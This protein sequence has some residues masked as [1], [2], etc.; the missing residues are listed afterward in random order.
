MLDRARFL[1]V[2]ATLALPFLVACGG[3][4][5]PSADMGSAP[6]DGPE[7]PEVDLG[8]GEEPDVCEQEGL[9]RAAFRAGAGTVFGEVAGDF[10]VRT[11][12][13][14]WQLSESF[15]GCESYVFITYIP[16]LRQSPIGP[17][18]GDEMWDT[19][20]DDLF[21]IGPRNVR[22]FFS[23]FEASEV[24]RRERME[25]MRDNVAE[26]L[27]VFVDDE[28]DRAF[29]RERFH[30]VTDR[31]TEIEGSVGAMV[32]SYFA[33]LGTEE[34]LTDLGDRGVVQAPL[35]FAFGIDREQRFD[36]G[37]SLSPVVGATLEMGM[38]AYFG[39][40]YNAK[41]ELAERLAAEEATTTV[42]PLLEDTV[43]DRVFV[44]AV[45]LPD[46]ATMAAFDTLEVE[47][48]VE[49]TA[50]S[51]FECSEWDRIARVEV[52]L[53]AECAERR[54][55]VRWIT[56]YWR[57]GR[58]HWSIDATPMLGLLLEGGERTFRIEMGPSWERA[59]PRRA[60]IALRLG[61]RD[62]E[63]KPVATVPAFGGGRFDETYNDREP[64]AFT[65][66]ADAGRVELVVILS[67]HGDDD[68]SRCAEWCDH[69][70]EFAVNDAPLD[71]IAHG[72]EVGTTAGC[73]LRADEGIPPGQWG[74]WAPERA[75]WCPGLPVD[76][77]RIDITDRVTLGQENTLTYAGGVGPSSTPGG[78]NISLSSYLVYYR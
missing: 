46:A 26:G 27:E 71:R 74:N 44:E 2:P 47:V 51:P 52:C 6:D 4:T 20:P 7:I 66:P 43:T 77:I 15:S 58:R 21:R 72:G 75:F 19:Y 22:Y 57:R 54:E 36:A 48:E 73:A 18:Q 37:G 69:R 1:V 5:G 8:P 56:P 70:H 49:C 59:T 39:H 13:G 64:V 76:A 24:R 40:F 17:W 16:D 28:E 67:G 78:G 63:Q 62:R 25:A 42:V 34:A 33:Y 11:L 12:E 30:Y 9:P 14:P 29:W 35:P 60:R 10:T 32:D 50:R 41:A 68:V 55:V 65:P 61:D 23:S 45:T 38:A 3:T 53:D 31:V